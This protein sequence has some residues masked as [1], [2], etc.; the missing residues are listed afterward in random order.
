MK[1]FPL[2]LLVA[3]LVMV[4]L[5]PGG[6][7]RG[8]SDSAEDALLSMLRFVPD[9]PENRSMIVYGDPAAWYE[10]WGVTAPLEEDLIPDLDADTR[11]KLMFVMPDQTL[12]PEAL[13]L[14]YML[15]APD[16]GD[17]YGFDLFT[18]DRFLYA[19]NPPDVLTVLDVITEPDAIAAALTSNGY[20][21]ETLDAGTLFSLNDD[22]GFDLAFEGPAVGRMGTLNRIALLDDGTVLVARATPVIEASLAALDGDSVADLP[23]YQAAVG[24]LGDEALAQAG[25]LVGTIFVEGLQAEDPALM[26]FGQN[27]TQ[28]QIDALQAQMA[29]QTDPPLAP[30]LLTAFATFHTPGA[31]S[32]VLAVVFPAGVDAQAMA[33]VLGARMQDYTSLRTQQ[34]MSDLWALDQAVGVDVDGLPIALVSMR[35]DDPE[36]LAEGDSVG[37]MRVLAWQQMIFARDLGFLAVT[38][39]EE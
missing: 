14:Q 13:G 17:Y 28:E 31:T 24:A 29:E 12:P 36:P 38:A 19:S 2:V 11:A 22:Y 39:P 4:A 35:V 34:P 21:S 1:R 20:A 27:V 5:L 9:T 18:T 10:S 37:S 32:L 15:T 7:V 8:Q 30:Y 3:L 26:L 25:L 33:D 6:A 16:Q 23:T